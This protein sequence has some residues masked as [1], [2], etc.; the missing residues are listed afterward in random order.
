VTFAPGRVGNW[1]VI[2]LRD[3]RVWA[4]VAFL[5]IPAIRPMAKYLPDVLLPAIPIYLI[6]TL[7]VY[8]VVLHAPGAR[9][10]CRRLERRWWPLAAIVLAAA[11]VSGAAYP[12]VDALKKSGRGSDE[13]DQLI[14]TSQRL[15]AGNRPLYVPT[16]LGNAPTAGPGWALA[17]SPLV[18]SGTYF[19]LTPLALAALPLVISSTSNRPAIAL[20]I[21]LPVSSPAFWELL[22]T[23][24]DIFPV[25]VV[26]AALTALVI[27]WPTR[28]LLHRLACLVLALVAVSTRFVLVYGVVLMGCFLWKRSKLGAVLLTGLSVGF[29]I[30]QCLAWLPQ[31]EWTPLHLLTRRMTALGPTWFLAG[32]ACSALVA[33]AAMRRADERAVTWMEGMWA[34]FAMPLVVVSVAD[35]VNSGFS[36]SAWRGATYFA[37]AVPLLVVAIAVRT[38]AS[39]DLRS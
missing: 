2:G 7:L 9:R 38:D 23:G 29:V 20:G 39:P 15:I 26:F 22:A 33:V 24:S 18:L 36:F 21:L 1:I 3:W 28:E 34:G 31:P 19:L 17:V 14:Q 11:L 4:L 30:V 5:Q 8:A 35:L 10:M 32:A 37:T 6:G 12:R 27:H 13:D 16:Y 25:G